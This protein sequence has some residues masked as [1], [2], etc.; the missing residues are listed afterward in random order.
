MARDFSGS[1]QYLQAADDAS[2]SFPTGGM[3]GAAT[4]VIETSTNYGI[5]D[6]YEIGGYEYALGVF[7][8][9]V[10]LIIYDNSGPGYIGCTAPSIGTA[11]S[12]GTVRVVFTYGGGTA[13]SSSVDGCH[14]YANGVLIED[15]YLTG[16]AFTQMRDTAQPFSV[17]R[18]SALVIAAF[19]GQ[20]S[21]VALWNQQLTLSEAQSYGKGFSPEMIAPRALKHYWPIW[22]NDSTEVDII[23]AQGL[24]NTS[25]TK[26][27]HHRMYYPESPG[28]FG[29]E[30]ASAAGLIWNPLLGPLEAMRYVA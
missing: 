25:T 24:V 11:N 5:M 12:D 6:K 8:S 17:G 21:E 28:F 20:M 22:G 4:L 19:D 15:T 9:V 26:A 14:L 18:M 16:G 7:S 23:G 10:Y 27:A 1:G 29:L 2:L 13:P 3:S 30:V